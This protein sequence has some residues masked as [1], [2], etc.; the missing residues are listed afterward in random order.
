MPGNRGEGRQTERQRGRNRERVTERDTQCP[1][2]RE[3]LGEQPVL[4]KS[5]VTLLSQSWKEHQIQQFYPLS[6][7]V[8][9]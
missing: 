1:G 3:V 8:K 5:S 9:R 7:K 6:V 2:E 4:F